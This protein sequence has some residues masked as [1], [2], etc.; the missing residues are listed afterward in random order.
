M[1]SKIDIK[2]TGESKAIISLYKA[3]QY[4]PYYSGDVI[5]GKNGIGK[6]HEGDFKTPSG[7]FH[8]MM[9]F[10]CVDNPGTTLNYIKI[11]DSYYWSDD[12]PHYNKLVHST[13]EKIS[14]EHLT[15]YSD[16]YKLALVLD[17]NKDCVYGK[18]SAIFMHCT[19]PGKT[20]TAG[21][22]ALDENILLSIMKNCT[23][24]TDIYIHS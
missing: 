9:A 19:V 16:A 17:Y 10:G 24:D 18:G 7:H 12:L 8:F 11:D 3:T 21:C 15:D 23:L 6:V 22:V 2:Y 20:Y 14:G 4:K 5:V 1:I 13:G